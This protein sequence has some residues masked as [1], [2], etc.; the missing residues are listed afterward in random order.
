[1][2]KIALNSQINES[3]FLLG[4]IGYFA[5]CKFSMR[6]LYG[7]KR[8][9]AYKKG[10]KTAPNIP[11]IL[12]LGISFGSAVYLGFVAVYILCISFMFNNAFVD[13]TETEREKKRWI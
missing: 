9:H 12:K 10:T 2:P 8:M 6:I 1:M 11:Q 3:V 7:I 13:R 5:K 4:F